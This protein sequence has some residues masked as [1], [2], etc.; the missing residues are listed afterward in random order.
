MVANL[1]NLLKNLLPLKPK[2]NAAERCLEAR[3]IAIGAEEKKA[4]IN[5]KKVKKVY[6][7]F[8]E[9]HIEYAKT[10]GSY[11]RE[12]YLS[13]L[14]YDDALGLV[15]KSYSDLDIKLIKETLIDLFIEDGF[16]VQE[17]IKV[18]DEAFNYVCT[19]YWG[20]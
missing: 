19:I 4:S 1:F 3:R 13:R 14:N 16:R 18:G 17:F 8:I 5:L 20:E 15:D 10:C 7:R 9:G 6:K 11:Y 12:I 2:L